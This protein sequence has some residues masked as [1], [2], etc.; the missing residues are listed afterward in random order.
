MKRTATTY[1]MARDERRKERER[2]RFKANTRREPDDFELR[3]CICA[4]IFLGA[5]HNANGYISRG[6]FRFPT[7]KYGQQGNRCCNRCNTI[8]SKWRGQDGMP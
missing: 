8:V 6:G 7:S 2:K 3:C 4:K 5:G 1:A